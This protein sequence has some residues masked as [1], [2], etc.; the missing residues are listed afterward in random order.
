M[1]FSFFSNLLFLKSNLSQQLKKTIILLLTIFII[2]CEKNSP[3]VSFYFWKTKFKLSTLERQTI[4][5]NDVKK[6]YLR[7]FDVALQNESALPVSPVY[8]LENLKNKANINIIFN[9]IPIIANNIKPSIM[10]IRCFF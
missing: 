3:D 1:I 6:I 5:N 7:Y 9:N 10:A 4:I 8:I 2:S